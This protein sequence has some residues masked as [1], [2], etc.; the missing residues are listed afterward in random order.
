MKVGVLFSG[1]KDSTYA[2][3]LAKKYGYKVKCIITIK[4]KNKES[5]MF[6]TASIDKVE[7]QAEAMET[8]LIIEETKGVKEEELFDLEKAIKKAIKKFK[9]EGIVAGA[10][11]SIYQSS[12]IQKICNKL[13]IECFNPLWQKDQFELLQDLIKNKFNVIIIG[14]AAEGFDE[15]WLGRRLDQKM[16]NE[17][18][19]LKKEY[20]I[21]PSF[22]GGEAETFVLNCPLFEKKLKVINSKVYGNDNSWRMELE[23]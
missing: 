23:L 1:G 2:C 17:L 8:P 3:Y 10:V 6:H 9:I 5:Y 14:V 20:G 22:E 15:S 18:M 11:E 21:S 4:S 19:V 13:G 16:I 12:R 7:K